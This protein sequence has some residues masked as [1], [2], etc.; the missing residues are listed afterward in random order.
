MVDS[1]ADAQNHVDERARQPTRITP[2]GGEDED[3]EIA[4]SSN[5]ASKHESQKDAENNNQKDQ[6]SAATELTHAR[7]HSSAA[8]IGGNTE[9][10]GHP[11]GSEGAELSIETV[12]DSRKRPGSPTSDHE[13][14]EKRARADETHS[15]TPKP[16]A[17]EEKEAPG[18]STHTVS[19]S[20]SAFR[21]ER[22]ASVPA[23][24]QALWGE[25]TGILNVYIW[26]YLHRRNFSRSA[27]AFREE[28]GL[29]AKPDVPLQTSMGLLSEYLSLIH[30]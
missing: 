30:I 19:P 5:D 16:Q 2:P 28:A 4:E 21:P 20:A 1:G 17:S 24:E 26:D 22:S 3:V 12:P 11:R 10:D 23:R 9:S 13:Q 6:A 29:P 8:A 27:E 15:S 18:T 7:E 25:N 14:R